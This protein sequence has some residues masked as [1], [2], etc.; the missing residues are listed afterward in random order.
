MAEAGDNVV[1]LEPAQEALRHGFLGW[2]C[3]LRQLAV[4]QH[5]GKPTPGMCPVLHVA[6]REIGP[7]TVVLN[8]V[9]HQQ[10]LSQFR[11][12]A[13]RTHDPRERFKA[14]VDY[15]SATYFQ[16]PA[17]FTDCLT[18]LFG[19]EATLPGR[20]AGRDDCMLAFTQFSQSFQLPC[21]ATLLPADTPAYQ[22]TYWH[23][24]LFNPA[25]PG[26][27]RILAFTPDWARAQAD[28]PPLGA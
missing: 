16:T 5:S 15:L 10:D 17:S 1:R 7:V 27:A 9:D 20:I 3:R 26:D 19:P 22:A 14:A 11:F 8:K 6:G 28:P 23:N 13:K 12:M 25:T 18:A 4:R 2:Q 24:V 21:T